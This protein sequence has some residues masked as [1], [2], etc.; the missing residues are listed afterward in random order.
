MRHK[1]FERI[2]LHP[3]LKNTRKVSGSMQD[4]QYFNL[5]I[6]NAVENQ[7]FACCETPDPRRQLIAFPACFR[8]LAEDLRTLIEPVEQRISSVYVVPCNIEPDLK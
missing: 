7:I 2:L 4:S 6:C 5:D 1:E 3:F 8:M